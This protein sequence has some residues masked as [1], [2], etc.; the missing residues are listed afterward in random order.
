M[1]EPFNPFAKPEEPVADILAG[2]PAESPTDEPAVLGAGSRSTEMPEEPELTGLAAVY[3]EKEEDKQKVKCLEEIGK[4]LKKHGGM[5]SN[6]GLNDEYWD[7][8]ALYRKF[9]A[10]P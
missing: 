4:I 6:V 8:T 5:E 9:N 7:L 3:V 2:T 1:T 10:N